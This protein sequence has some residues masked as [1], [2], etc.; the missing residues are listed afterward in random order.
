MTE[1]TLS[2]LAA[3]GTLPPAIARVCE[4]PVSAAV[5]RRAKSDNQATCDRVLDLQSATDVSNEPEADV[6][7]ESD[8]TLVWFI[9]SL[10]EQAI[11]Q[12]AS[13]STSKPSPRPSP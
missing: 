9:N 2:R 4:K 13:D 1:S 3:P 10:F 6:V 7:N 5:S 8:N 11:A 12:K